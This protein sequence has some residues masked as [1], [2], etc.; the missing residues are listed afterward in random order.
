MQ[1]K[2][3]LTPSNFLKSQQN[4]KLQFDVFHGDRFFRQGNKCS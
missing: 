4:I 1:K 3:F 2:I